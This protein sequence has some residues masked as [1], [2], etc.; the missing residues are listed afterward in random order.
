MTRE[1]QKQDQGWSP[2][3]RHKLQELAELISE[4]RFG[5]AGIPLEF[6]FSEIEEIGHQVGQLAAGTIDQALQQQHA[7]HLSETVPCPGCGRRCQVK[8]HERGIQTRD[9]TVELDEPACYCPHCERD[10]FPQRSLLGLDGRAYSPAVL[11]R[12]VAAGG[13]A[14]S[15]SVAA[16]LLKLIGEIDVSS[17]HVDNLTVLVGEELATERDQQTTAYFDQPLPRQP[18]R[19]EPS[20][21]LACVE[22]E[23]S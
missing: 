7:E 10:F 12:I 20:P 5:E 21:P 13:L 9:G 18:T 11:E 2:A 3:V 19:V 1:G 4:E 6:S 16:K 15:F 23:E 14:K 17:R 22:I 8:R